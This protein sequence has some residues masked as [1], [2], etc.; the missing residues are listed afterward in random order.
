MILLDS[1]AG[2]KLQSLLYNRPLPP[3]WVRSRSAASQPLT[4]EF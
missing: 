2:D 1:A 3:E 4:L